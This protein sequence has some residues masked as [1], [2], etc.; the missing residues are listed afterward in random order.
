MPQFIESLDYPPTAEHAAEAPPAESKPDWVNAE[1][2]VSVASYQA[3]QILYYAFIALMAVAGLDKFLHLSASWDTFVSPAMVRILHMSPG[4]IAVFAGLI[5]LVAAAAVALRPR[6]GSWVVTVWMLMI[7]VNL[8][9]MSG[10]YHIAIAD[11]AL[12]AAGFAFTRLSAEC[13]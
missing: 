4:S 6:I 5:E 13:N 7:V 9:T 11:L 12:A 3:Y 2:E 1:V 8:L 10:H